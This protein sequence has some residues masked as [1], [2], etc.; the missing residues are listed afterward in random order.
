MAEQD[1]IILRG[2]YL[3]DIYGVERVTIEAEIA[4]QNELANMFVESW[5]PYMECHKCGKSDYCKYAQPNPVN[6]HKKLEIKCGV[7]ETAIRNFVSRT[8][9]VATKLEPRQLQDYL[10]GAF[11]LCRFVLEAEQSVG[12][13]ID[14]NF[15]D[16][17]GD[18]SPA[19]FGRFTELR[20]TLNNLARCFRKIPAFHA[21][22]SLLLVEGWAEKAFLEKLRESHS[23][24]YLDLLVECYQ[25]KGNRRSKRIS[26]LL[27]RY[28]DIGYKIYAQGDA[29]G[30]PEEIFKGLIDAGD[31]SKECTF[32]FKHDFETA[33]PLALLANAMR[34]IGIKIEF[35]LH[36]LQ[37][38]LAAGNASV[39]T[40]LKKQ[41]NVDLEPNKIE[42]ATAIAEI[43]VGTQHAWWQD[44]NFMGSELGQFLDFVHKM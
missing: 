5:I 25:G 37:R 33:V 7:C 43:L 3:L 44:E 16:W 34:R 19:S 13:A 12:T 39:N 17:L 42:L 14:N 26:M 10:D 38:A 18:Y 1:I 4:T 15:L 21:N 22:R 11:Y 40:V 20:D 36:D 41:F 32:S 35:E 30:K 9:A 29:D 2:M 27:R 8:F 24:W 28:L 31:L 6:P 23:A